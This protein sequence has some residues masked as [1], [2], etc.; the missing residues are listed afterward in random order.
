[1]GVP[2]DQVGA[3]LMREGVDVGTLKTFA[4]LCEFRKR[5]GPPSAPDAAT[6][7]SFGGG[8]AGPPARGLASRSSRGAAAQATTSTIAGRHS[9]QPAPTSDAAKFGF[10]GGGGGG[11]SGL[12]AAPVRTQPPLREAPREAAAARGRTPSS[13]AHPSG[14]GLSLSLTRDDRAA[15]SAPAPALA[16]AKPAAAPKAHARGR[17][18]LQRANRLKQVQRAEGLENLPS[19]RAPSGGYHDHGGFE[20]LF[21]GRSV[22]ATHAAAGYAADVSRLGNASAYVGYGDS[23]TSTGGGG[24]GYGRGAS[25]ERFGSLVREAPFSLISLTRTPHCAGTP[26]AP[27]HHTCCSLLTPPCLSLFEP[28]RSALHAQRGVTQGLSAQRPQHYQLHTQVL[29]KK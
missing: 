12:D 24:Y 19:N 18:A 13:A 2:A 14:G 1:V 6:S 9:R 4:A 29:R 17:E 8:G 27:A 28:A 25:A 20:A 7:F 22:H 26:S 21:G 10:G 5:V 11:L 15:S 23:N 3:K 16:W